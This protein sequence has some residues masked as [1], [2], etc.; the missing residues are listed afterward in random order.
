MADDGSPEWAERRG[1]HRT[2]RCLQARLDLGTPPARPPVPPGVEL[3]PFRDF[4]EHPRAVYALDV[5]TSQDEPGDV[6]ADAV[7]YAD[8]L[9]VVWSHP[10]L[11][12]DLSLLA[13]VDG[14]PAALTFANTDG[15]TR[16]RS[17]LT[18]TLPDYRGRG[19]ARLTKAH[20]LHRAHARGL[21]E[22]F[23]GN[24]EDNAPMRAVNARLGYRPYAVE[25]C[26]SREPG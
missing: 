26:L 2:R 12:L 15:G 3:R 18:G 1:F 14:T 22:A 13:V 20:S 17:G 8:W 21:R 10:A 7:G 5:A 6:S 25:V 23:T 9:D 24:D 11:D 19:L 16:Y 4:A